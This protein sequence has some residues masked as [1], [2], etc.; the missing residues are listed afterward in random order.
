MAKEQCTCVNPA[1]TFQ[2]CPKCSTKVCKNC[3]IPIN[4]EQDKFQHK[5]D[6]PRCNEPSLVGTS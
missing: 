3:G 6:D 5:N 4:N 2:D 1:E